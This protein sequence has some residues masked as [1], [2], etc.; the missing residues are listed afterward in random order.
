MIIVRS[1]FLF[2]CLSQVSMR[3]SALVHY[4]NTYD[5]LVTTVSASTDGDT[6]IIRDDIIMYSS[7]WLNKNL[8]FE[9]E[10][11]SRYSLDGAGSSRIFDVDGGRQISL[12]NLDIQNGQALYDG[13]GAIFCHGA[14]QLNLT[15]STLMSNT[16]GNVCVW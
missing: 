1:V 6:I 3:G 4:V 5:S 9:C 15:G 12:I 8:N 16:A 2:S 10:P 14:C 13:G 11:S 7:I